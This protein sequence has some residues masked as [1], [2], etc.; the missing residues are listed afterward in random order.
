MSTPSYKVRLVGPG[1]QQL[2]FE[3]SASISEDRS[4]NWDSYNIVQLPAEI[5]A[6]RNSGSRHFSI[7]GK[8][9]SRTSEEAQQNLHYLDLA[10]AWTLPDFGGTGAT[11]PFLKLYGY[12]NNNIDGRQVILKN[13]S[14]SFPDESDYRWVGEVGKTQCIPIIG[15]LSLTVEEI[16]TAEQITNK[17][18]MINMTEGIESSDGPTGELTTFVGGAN[19]P[20][21]KSKTFNFQTPN[22]NVFS[23]VLNLSKPGSIFSVGSMIDRNSLSVPQQK[24]L[25]A[26]TTNAGKAVN[27]NPLIQEFTKSS[28]L[29]KNV[30]VSG[31]TVLMNTLTPKLTL[32]S[33]PKQASTND[34]FS[35]T[36][37]SPPPIIES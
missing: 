32:Q 10:R 15:G 37:T 5:A 4:A 3:A 2:V 20:D 11:P 9:V 31:S 27:N 7:T 16:Y 1:G 35:R 28:S 23:S 34:S 17:L 8:L 18:W 22:S 21:F 13:Y 14:W 33:T 19:G 26:L 30:F 12:N 25:N 29:V 36:S 24:L 6:Y